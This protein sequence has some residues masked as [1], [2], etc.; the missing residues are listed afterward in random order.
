M[1]GE[2]QGSILGLVLFYISFGDK[3]SEIESTLSKFSDDTKLGSA[4][5]MLEK[6]D[7]I[8]RDLDRLASR[9]MQKVLH[10]DWGLP[11]TN[12]VW[13]ENGLRKALRGRTWGCW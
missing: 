11:T 7:D 1:S 12:R 6:R 8:Q 2:P 4:V 9:P 13:S 3:D 5:N 10:M